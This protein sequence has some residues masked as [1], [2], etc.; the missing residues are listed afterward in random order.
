VL[1][2]LRIMKQMVKNTDTPIYSTLQDKVKVK[3]A[4]LKDNRDNTDTLLEDY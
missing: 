1:L 4:S 3:V 2:K